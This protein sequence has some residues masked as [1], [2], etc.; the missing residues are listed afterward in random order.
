MQGCQAKALSVLDKHNR[1]VGN[2]HANLDHRCGHQDVY[3]A[4]AELGDDAVLLFGRHAT[5]QRLDALAPVGDAQR[6]D[7]LLNRVQRRGDHP[8]IV[9]ALEG[10]NV[11]QL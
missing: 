6:L 8:A 9:I 10:G 2:V 3:L 11:F 1:G 7:I 5:V 4:G